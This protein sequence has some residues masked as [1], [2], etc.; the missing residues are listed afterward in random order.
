MKRRPPKGNMRRVRANNDLHHPNMRF[1]LTNKAG[2]TIQCESF[3]EYAL[4]MGFNRD[5][6]V[7]DFGSQPETFSFVDEKGKHHTY[8]PDFIVW[9]VDGSVAIH[10]MSLSK[11]R[12]QP[13]I[14]R[15]ERAARAICAARPGWCY[16]VHTELELPRGAVLA[17]LEM[18]AD[19][20]PEVY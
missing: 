16:V 5:P 13:E 1:T 18:L 4:V 17:N 10:E 15:R 2:R 3:L 14:Q 12:E 8:T 19:H 11:R 7:Q 20:A 9:Y 6:T